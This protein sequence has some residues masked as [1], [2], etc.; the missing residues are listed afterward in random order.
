MATV[1]TQRIDPKSQPLHTEVDSQTAAVSGHDQKE[2]ENLVS[3]LVNNVG[4]EEE[5]ASIVAGLNQE[6][7]SNPS[8]R[9]L[10]DLAQVIDSALKAARVANQKYQEASKELESA[11]GAAK[12]SDA[13]HR[14]ETSSYLREVLDWAEALSGK[15][16]DSKIA[17]LKDV[18]ARLVDRALPQDLSDLKLLFST[19]RQA[20]VYANN[21][22]EIAET[23]NW[24]G[25][26]DEERVM[27]AYNS[28]RKSRCDPPSARFQPYRTD[29]NNST[30][31]KKPAEL[32][33]APSASG[34]GVSSQFPPPSIADAILKLNKVAPSWIN[35]E[36]S[37]SVRT[38]KDK[39][40]SDKDA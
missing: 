32:R 24:M 23:K 14:Q 22:I 8:K 37:H 40:S 12:N 26:R 17:G 38:N 30:L 7:F 28:I 11:K 27:K 6:D 19:V 33:G 21:A 35:N 34:A 1:D 15:K 31:Q 25:H 13:L 36:S 20:S 10:A 16:D 4:L 29:D 9:K 39:N 5:I 3:D 2:V 18:A